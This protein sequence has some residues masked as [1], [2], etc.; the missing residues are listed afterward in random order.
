MCP[1]LIHGG[2]EP[3]ADADLAYWQSELWPGVLYAIE[4]YLR[5]GWDPG[6]KQL[7]RS[8]TSTQADHNAAACGCPEFGQETPGHDRGACR[9][10]PN[11]TSVI[12]MD[13]FSQT[14]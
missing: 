12:L 13:A 6:A 5:G 8:P 1:A 11:S 4:A 7:G 3:D 9:D 10:G 14:R 2:L